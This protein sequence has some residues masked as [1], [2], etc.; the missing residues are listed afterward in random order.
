MRLLWDVRKSKIRMH[1]IIIK[2]AVCPWTETKA[3]RFKSV[4]TSGKSDFSVIYLQYSDVCIAKVVF[5]QYMYIRMV[6]LLRIGLNH[7]KK[8]SFWV[9]SI[10]RLFG[11]SSKCSLIVRYR[12]YSLIVGYVQLLIRFSWQTFKSDLDLTFLVSSS[13]RALRG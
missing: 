10:K 11:T 9:C 4:R 8:H 1:G 3:Y 12:L 5:M 7:A 6:I 13:A 2:T